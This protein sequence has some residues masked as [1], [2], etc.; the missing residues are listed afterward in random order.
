MQNFRLLDSLYWLTYDLEYLGA[1]FKSLLKKNQTNFKGFAINL[2]AMDVW[3]YE[4]C[5]PFWFPFLPRLLFDP[6][7]F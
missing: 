2:G 1:R 5:R 4:L 7:H 6:A 3:K